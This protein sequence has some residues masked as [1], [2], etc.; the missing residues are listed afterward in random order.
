MIRIFW[1]SFFKLKF[2]SIANFIVYIKN[3]LNWNNK[4]EPKYFKR[5]DLVWF[6]FYLTIWSRI[7]I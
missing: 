7:E 4:K 1:F 5:H 2:N 6:I 3:G